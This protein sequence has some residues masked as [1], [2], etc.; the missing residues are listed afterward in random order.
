[1]LYELRNLETGSRNTT[2]KRTLVLQR[3]GSISFKTS[4]A[5]LRKWTCMG[6]QFNHY[7]STTV[8]RVVDLEKI[9]IGV[10]STNPAFE[11]AG[12]SWG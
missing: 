7:G 3:K 6:K 8:M 1:M 2:M 4:G 12:R 11:H 9:F 10:D 5:S